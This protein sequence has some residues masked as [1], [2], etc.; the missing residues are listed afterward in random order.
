MKKMNV[1]VSAIE[2]HN[3]LQITLMNKMLRKT[4]VLVYIYAQELI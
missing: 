1:S 3:N 4:I 2:K